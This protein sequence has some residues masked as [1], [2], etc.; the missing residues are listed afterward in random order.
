MSLY[1][2]N[3]GL[4]TSSGGKGYYVHEEHKVFDIVSICSGANEKKTML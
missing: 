1:I 2:C 4:I 3:V